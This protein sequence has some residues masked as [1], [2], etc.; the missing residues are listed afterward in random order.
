MLLHMAPLGRLSHQ[1]PYPTFSGRRQWWLRRDGDEGVLVAN[2]IDGRMP[3]VDQVDLAAVASCSLV[4][5]E[6][7]APGQQLTLLP[8]PVALA[9]AF[10]LG[11]GEAAD[12]V[13]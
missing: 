8:D 5:V 6:V 1:L 4:A 11:D 9:A 12:A 3:V 10:G 2:R 13:T 7:R